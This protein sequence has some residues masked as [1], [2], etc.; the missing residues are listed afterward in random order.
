MAKR[1]PARSPRWIVYVMRGKRAE[2]R[3]EVFADTEAEAIEEAC[4]ELGITQ[5]WQRRRVIVRREE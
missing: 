2:R 3:G 5:D 4:R 1:P